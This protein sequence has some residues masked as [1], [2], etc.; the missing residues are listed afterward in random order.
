MRSTEQYAIDREKLNKV[1][2]SKGLIQVRVCEALGRSHGYLS[3]GTCDKAFIDG[4]ERYY[5]IR[6]E[7]IKPDYLKPVQAETEHHKTDYD[8]LYEL[9]RKA[10]YEGMKQA[11]N[12]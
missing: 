11:L 9:I 5:G 4:L 2:K 3:N 10:V 7:D 1:L 12:E 6:Y 8:K